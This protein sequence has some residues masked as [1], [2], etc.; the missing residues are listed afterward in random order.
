MKTNKLIKITRLW[1]PLQ[2]VLAILILWGCNSELPK[3]LETKEIPKEFKGSIVITG[4]ESLCPLM[5]IWAEEFSSDKPNLKIL[6]SDWGTEKGLID[7]LSGK[8]DLAMV[9]RNL[10]P[11]EESMGLW[12]FTVSK[13]GVI[14]I[15]N[16]NN[17]YLQEIL[18]KGIQRTTLIDL[19]TTKNVI[20]WGDLIGIKYNKPV[21]IFIRSDYTG[22]A[23]VWCKYL[24]KEQKD[25]IGIPISSYQ[26]IVEAVSQEPMSLSFCN[27][28]N[29]YNLKNNKIRKGLSVLP[30]DFD[31][32]GRI[33]S[34]EQFYEDLCRVQRA[35]YLGKYPSHLCRELYLVSMEKPT[36]PEIINFLKWIY[37][38]GQKIAAKAGYAELKSCQTK[39]LI[40]LLDKL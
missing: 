13:E 2:Y 40:S 22:T 34:K 4:A 15:I 23:E 24:G 14:P 16:E 1:I 27:A 18:S 29:A 3:E 11:A 9:S 21:K 28:H 12:Y 32:N 30:I 10:T 36:K 37:T 17:P 6:V 33:D 39:E 31:N 35:A 19:F 38:D 25:L 20:T 8:A 5:K 7:L 26:Q